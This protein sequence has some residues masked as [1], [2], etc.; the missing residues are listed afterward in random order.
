MRVNLRLLGMSDIVLAA[1]KVL[2]LDF[3]ERRGYTV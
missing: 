3:S 1:C 2:L